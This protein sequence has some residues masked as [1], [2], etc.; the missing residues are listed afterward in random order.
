MHFPNRP[1]KNKNLQHLISLTAAQSYVRS[2]EHT[3]QAITP[4]RGLI[5]HSIYEYKCGN[6][7]KAT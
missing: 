4:H 7:E 2:P 3:V 5:F 1:L 6:T